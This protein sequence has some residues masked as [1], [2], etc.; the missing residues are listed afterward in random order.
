MR[1]LA[2]IASEVTGAPYRYEPASDE[3]WDARWRALGREGW[4]LEAGQ[5]SYEAIRRGEL[6]VVSD[7]YRRLTG[8]E[9]LTIAEVLAR[10]SW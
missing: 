6:D 1:E 9:P 3:D 4:E 2:A 10:L 8:L 7:D 5:T